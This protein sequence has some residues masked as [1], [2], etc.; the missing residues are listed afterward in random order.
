MLSQVNR[1]AD[2]TGMPVDDP[3]RQDQLQKA[4]DALHAQMVDSLL[5]NRQPGDAINYLEKNRG[6]VSVGTQAKLQDQIT[7]VSVVEQATQASLAVRSAGTLSQ[8]QNALTE[9]YKDKKLSAD[10]YQDAKRMVAY[11]YNIDVEEASRVRAE[12]L[13]GV[14]QWAYQNPGKPLSMAPTDI[15]TTVGNLG[16]TAEAN[17]MITAMQEQ[18]YSDALN[19]VR[20]MLASDDGRKQLANMTENDFAVQYMP[21]M[22]VSD[23]NYAKAMHATARG[24]PSIEQVSLVSAKDR[25]LKAAWDSGVIP[26]GVVERG[27]NSSEKEKMVNFEMEVET[28]LKQQA[29]DNKRPN[30][31]A[32]VQKYLDQLVLRKI[33]KV[34]IDDRSAFTSDD[35]ISTM[36]ATEQQLSAA[37]FKAASGDIIYLRYQP[38]LGDKAKYI[39]PSE[40][41]RIEG[42]L[43]AE[44][45]PVTNYNRIEIWKANEAVFMSERNKQK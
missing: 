6:E 38:E 17:K 26:K 16:I 35:E 34:Y 3:I 10:A 25:V 39:S 33:S 32:D 22:N 28:A 37:Y 21:R 18:S 27:F 13:N 1:V 11:D 15:L 45:L 43:R 44:G 5:A 42:I 4:S 23:F 36:D 31:D 12:G 19:G 41:T 29:I 20:S 8:R 7:R 30:T 24:N 9:M 40:M 14:A 2:M